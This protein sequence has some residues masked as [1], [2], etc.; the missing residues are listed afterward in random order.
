MNYEVSHGYL[1]GLRAR[2]FLI[3]IGFRFIRFH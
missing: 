2:Y 3:D 1:Y